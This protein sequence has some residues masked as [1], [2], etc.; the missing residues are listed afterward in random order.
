MN[1]LHQFLTGKTPEQVISHLKSLKVSIL[2]KTVSGENLYLFNY[3]DDAPRGQPLVEGCRGVVFSHTNKENNDDDNEK[4]DWTCVRSSFDRFYNYGEDHSPTLPSFDEITIQEKKDGTLLMVT[5]YKGSLFIGTRNMFDVI[6]MLGISGKKMDN[7]V[8]ELLEPYVPILIENSDKT[9][10]FEL[11]TPWNPVVVNHDEPHISLLG[12]RSNIFPYRE[13][14]PTHFKTETFQ[15]TWPSTFDLQNIAACKDEVERLGGANFEGFIL[16][17]GP[18]ET[19]SRIKLKS[20]TFLNLMRTGQARTSPEELLAS[21]I[22]DNDV[23]EVLAI[24]PAWKDRLY[25][26]VKCAMDA[27]DQ[28]MKSI[29]KKVGEL[30]E[31][32]QRKD[33]ALAASKSPFIVFHIEN[34]DKMFDDVWPQ[35][36]KENKA[37]IVKYILSVLNG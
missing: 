10:M 30:K 5:I 33:I 4:G 8:K 35:Y 32:V 16:K 1:H 34:R 15:P 13:Y 31:P 23:E 6:G 11:C 25:V 29:H 7:V 28:T 37:K 26:S 24:H 27:L 3:D 12:V 21:A 22:V 18:T 19:P 17:F 14:E 20:K 2:C 36:K 9:F